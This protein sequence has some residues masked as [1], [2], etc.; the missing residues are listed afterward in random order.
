MVDKDLDLGGF[1]YLIYRPNC[2]STIEMILNNSI[3]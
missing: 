3:K 1:T 2:G